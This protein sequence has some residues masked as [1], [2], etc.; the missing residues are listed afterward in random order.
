MSIELVSY[1]N[2]KNCYF[3][4]FVTVYNFIFYKY[5]RSTELQK[6]ANK[7]LHAFSQ[8][9]FTIFLEGKC[10]SYMFQY[11]LL[12]AINTIWWSSLLF[13]MSYSFWNK[14]CYSNAIKWRMCLF[15]LRIYFYLFFPQRTGSLK[16]CIKQPQSYLKSQKIEI[17]FNL[18]IIF[19]SSYSIY[20]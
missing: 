13:L 18:E 1:Y 15:L 7:T 20:R 12:V 10:L 17:K 4:Q 14:F 2:Y 11:T 9:S 19:L 8:I 5:R 3:V 6:S 16:S